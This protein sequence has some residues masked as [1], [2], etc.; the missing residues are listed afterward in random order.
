MNYEGKKIVNII[1]DL[2]GVLLNID[3]DATIQAFEKLGINSFSTQYSQAMQSDLFD[4][5]ETGKINAEQFYSGINDLLD[6]HLEDEEIKHAWNAMLLDLPPHRVE[7]LEKMKGS[8]KTF[9]LSNTNA[10][11]FQAYSQII[12]R[13]ND[14]ASMDA[15]FNQVYLSHEIGLRKPNKE[16]FEI[17][18]EEHNLNPEETLFIDDSLQHVEGAR[19]LNINAHH[20]RED[21]GQFIQSLG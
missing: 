21:I 4:H 19:S 10:I 11:H 1:F 12:K 20:L 15:L 9:L 17:I 6:A 7:L 16:S 14:L 3:Y 18:L 13:E 2:G 5:L 8:Y